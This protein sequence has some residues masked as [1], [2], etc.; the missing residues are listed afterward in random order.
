MEANSSNHR[1][2][3][4]KVKVSLPWLMRYPWWRAGE[5]L[6]RVISNGEPRHLI[7]I[8]ANHFEP[9]WNSKGENLDWVTQETRLEHWCRQAEAIGRSVQDSDGTPFRHTN[10]YPGEQYHPA[11]LDRLA[12][13]QAA[14]YG[15]VEIH[16]HHGVD[17]PDNAPNLRRALEEFRDVLA[18]RHGLLSRMPGHATPM[19]GFVHGNFALANSDGGRCCGVDEEMQILA[20]TG[21]YAD[22]TLPAIPYQAQVPRINAV[23]QCGYPLHE[24]ALIVQ[25]LTWR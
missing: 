22:F 25:G 12:A 2:F 21:C 11:L 14:G 15:E 10:F 1:S 9:S 7:I 23:Y 13:L 18:E 20:D 5:L 3:A 6:R 19:Y 8:V 4:S 24:R 17:Q 16:L